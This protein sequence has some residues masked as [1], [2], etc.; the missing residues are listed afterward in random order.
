N[1]AEVSRKG[2]EDESGASDDESEDTF[3]EL[4]YESK[5]VEEEEEYYTR[6]QFEEEETIDEEIPSLA[7]YLTILKEIPTVI[8]GE[9]GKR[10]EKSD[11]P[12]PPNENLPYQYDADS[13]VKHDPLGYHC[14]I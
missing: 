4:E 10:D 13:V 9:S 2:T 5:E 11:S 7:V 14:K 3:D 8:S 6:E 1:T 12:G